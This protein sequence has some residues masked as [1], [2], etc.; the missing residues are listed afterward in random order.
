[1]W[2]T[3]VNNRDLYDPKGHYFD[4]SIAPSNYAAE[5]L[6]Q[7]NYELPGL[8]PPL[9][10]LYALPTLTKGT[11]TTLEDGLDA[12]SMWT[13]TTRG[14]HKSLIPFADLAPEVQ[15]L[16]REYV[17]GIHQAASTTLGGDDER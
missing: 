15:E 9:A 17:D 6:A 10:N 8:D 3:T 7:V 2:W 5:M 13:A 12:W 1:M 16:D 4:D 14:A 11:A